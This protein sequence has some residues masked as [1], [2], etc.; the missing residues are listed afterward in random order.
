VT[1]GMEVRPRE[2][3]Q[4]ARGA[5]VMLSSRRRPPSEPRA[6]PTADG[7]VSRSMVWCGAMLTNL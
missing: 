7:R 3:T 2:Q 5:R 4:I 1:L 6:G